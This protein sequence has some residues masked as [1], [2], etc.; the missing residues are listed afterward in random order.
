MFGAAG[1]DLKT[2]TDAAIARGPAGSACAS[3]AIGD[4]APHVMPARRFPPPWSVRGAFIEMCCCIDTV[5]RFRLAVDL[6][7]AR[8]L[9]KL[10]TG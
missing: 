9:L 7:R 3:R 2:I 4:P 6:S 5:A 8:L 10:G 1:T